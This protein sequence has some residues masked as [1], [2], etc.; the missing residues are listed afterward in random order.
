M[1]QK[2]RVCGEAFHGGNDTTLLK[3]TPESGYFEF[4]FQQPFPIQWLMISHRMRHL[5][6]V[7][8]FCNQ[9]MLSGSHFWADPDAN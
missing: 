5:R 6:K 2:C 9:A 4:H 1:K 8:K 3:E 7:Q